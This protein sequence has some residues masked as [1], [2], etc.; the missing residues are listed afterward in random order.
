MTHTEELLKRAAFTLS[1]IELLTQS[2]KRHE[3]HNPENEVSIKQ[4]KRLRQE[5]SNE[6][7]L[8]LAELGADKPLLA[9]AA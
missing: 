6:L 3:T 2:I 5:M 7:Y 1:R 9:V 8:I 4:F